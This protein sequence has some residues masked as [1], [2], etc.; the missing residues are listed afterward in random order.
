MLVQH[1][2]EHC[3]QRPIFLA[4]DQQL[5][6]SPALR[7]GPELADPLG[8]LEV[9]QH[10]DVEQFGTRSGTDGVQTSPYATLE[11]IRSHG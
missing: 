10:Q 7:V 2:E 11:L 5:G 9:G 4:V 8:P 3:P 6:E 1:S